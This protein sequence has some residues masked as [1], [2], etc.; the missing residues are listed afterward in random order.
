[1]TDDRLRKEAL[2]YHSA[3]PAGKLTVVPTK[4]HGTSHE[5][6]LAY[7]PGVAFPCKEDRRLGVQVDRQEVE[8]LF[9]Q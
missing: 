4:P 9:V 2:D 5:L 1:M 3:K 8:G 7:S 6:S